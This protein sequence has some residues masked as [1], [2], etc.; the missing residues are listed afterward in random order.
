MENL[1]SID[2]LMIKVLFVCMGNICRSP[3]AEGIFKKLVADSNLRDDIFIDSAGTIGYHSGELPDARMRRHA[4]ARGYDLDSRARQF[5]LK[6][7]FEEFDFIITMD[8]D[9]YADITKLDSKNIYINKIFR[10]VDFLSD[11]N[12]SEVPDPYYGG[13]EGFEFVI[14]VLED[15]TKNLLTKI[16][17]DFERNN[18]T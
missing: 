6:N 18:Q 4:L 13:A 3:A 2:K 16:K 10:M 8:N 14:D 5:N 17:K 11:K 15:G 1:N 7:D 12:V 9:N